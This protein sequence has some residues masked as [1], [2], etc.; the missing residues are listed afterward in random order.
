MYSFLCSVLL[1]IVFLFL[2]PLCSQITLHSY[3]DFLDGGFLLTSKLLNQGF[4]EAKL[5]TS[6][7]RS[8]Y[9]PTVTWLTITESPCHGYVVFVIITIRPP[10]AVFSD[11][12]SP[13]CIVFYVV[14]YWLLF[15]FSFGHSVVLHVLRFL[16]YLH[17]FIY[18]KPYQCRK[19]DYCK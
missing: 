9:C 2:W 6:S 18:N 7:L 14:I 12:R 11:L 1:T 13:W 3:H 15:F 4:L 5:K 17:F 10:F 16:W 19:T 8:F